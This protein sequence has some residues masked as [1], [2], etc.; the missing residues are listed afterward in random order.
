MYFDDFR[1]FTDEEIKKWVKNY[2]EDEKVEFK[3]DKC[4][5]LVRKQK[6]QIKIFEN[7]LKMKELDQNI[8]QNEI[9]Y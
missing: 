3:L 5:K 2:I 6:Y 7:T 1:D 9:T 8:L 4:D